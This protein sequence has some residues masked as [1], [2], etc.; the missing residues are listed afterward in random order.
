MEKRNLGNGETSLLGFG[1]MRLPCID[2]TGKIDKNAAI[3]M[4]DTAIEGGVDYFDTAWMYHNG[5]SENFAGEALSRH[6]RTSYSLANKMPLAFIQTAADVERIFNEQLRKCRTDYFDYYLIH[7]IKQSFAEIASRCNV[8]EQL[9]RKKEAGYIRKLG[10]S[11]HDT[12]QFLKQTVE[13][14]HFDFA[15][16]QLNYVDWEQQNAGEQYEVLASRSIPVH[17]MEPV[18]GGAL[19]HPGNKA[20]SIFTRAQPGASPA[21]WALRYAASLQGVQV[22]LSGMSSPEQLN[23]NLKTF[24]PLVPLTANEYSVVS[25]AL[26]E[27]RK[28]GT[29]QCTGCR[30]CMNCPEGVDIPKNLAVY[31]N[32]TRNLHEKHPMCKFLFDMEYGLLKAAGQQASLCVSCGKCTN[33]CPQNID[34][35]VLMELTSSLEEVCRQ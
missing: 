25:R 32:Y 28:A 14:H 16:I 17:I 4:V 18:R 12:P 20:E 21:S 35:P 5:E 26:M 22:V 29:V 19:A 33:K 24:S 8:Y 31:N 23:D 6:S 1:L 10:F 7:N 2:G 15:Q 27:Y 34:I 13:E 30:Y 3:T 11:F 9:M